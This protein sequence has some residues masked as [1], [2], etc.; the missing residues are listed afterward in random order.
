MSSRNGY[1]TNAQRRAA[2]IL[3][4][5]LQAGEMA[6]REGVR[7]AIRIRRRMLMTLA[8][9]PMVQ[10]EYVSVCDPDS[11]EPLT[12]IT[13]TVVLLGAIRLGSIRLIDNLL[14]RKKNVQRLSRR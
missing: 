10:V 9:E 2:P 13:G 8:S 6:I 11:L 4:R 1:L 14:V 5:A 12:R 3:Y 7:H